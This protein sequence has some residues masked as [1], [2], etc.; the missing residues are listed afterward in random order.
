MEKPNVSH[1]LGGIVDIRDFAAFNSNHGRAEGDQLLHQLKQRFFRLA[2][3]GI[4]TLSGD[5]DEIVFWTEELEMSELRGYI[6]EIERQLRGEYHD[7]QMW[8]GFSRMRKDAFNSKGFYQLMNQSLPQIKL[9]NKAVDSTRY[10][11]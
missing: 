7:F 11:A 1:V 9:S 3:V 5:G 8:C 10:R 4:H 2:S 6:L